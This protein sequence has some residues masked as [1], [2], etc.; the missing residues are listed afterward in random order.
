MINLLL[1]ALIGISWQSKPKNS[2]L[3]NITF[4]A[5]IVSSVALN[6]SIEPIDEKL[7]IYKMVAKYMKS[8]SDDY[9]NYTGSYLIIDSFGVLDDN[10]QN[11][12]VALVD[13]KVELTLPND[14]VL[15]FMWSDRFNR[16]AI[17]KHFKRGFGPGVKY[18]SKIGAAYGRQ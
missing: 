8:N 9:G 7:G 4:S 16:D 12:L 17:V 11:F 18:V 13:N 5:E 1:A 15:A 3:G 2:D 10:D 6:V 14:L